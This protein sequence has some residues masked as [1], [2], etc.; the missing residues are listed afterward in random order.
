VL[1]YGG[2]PMTFCKITPRPGEGGKPLA[3]VTVPA[4]CTGAQS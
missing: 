1:D 4:A 2:A 3:R